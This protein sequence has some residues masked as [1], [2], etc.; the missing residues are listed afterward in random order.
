MKIESDFLLRLLKLKCVIKGVLIMIYRRG[1]AEARIS[2]VAHM[3]IKR[4]ADIEL[5]K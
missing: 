4:I 2:H 1:S 5:K 3:F